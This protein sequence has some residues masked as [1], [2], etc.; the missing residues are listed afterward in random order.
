[1]SLNNR[2]LIASPSFAKMDREVTQDWV[3]FAYHCGRRMPQYD[4]F[5]GLK[6]KSE[7]FRARNMIVEGAQQHNCDRILM[8]DDDMII[9]A[10][11]EGGVRPGDAADVYSFLA[12]LIAHDKDICGILYY[13]RG[14]ECQPV[15]MTKLGEK[16]Y[17]FLRD[18]EITHGLQRV[19]VTGGGCMLIK[20]RIFDRIPYPYFAPEFEF[21]TDIQLCR[22][23]AEKGF[24][25]W[26]DTAI[27][28]GHVRNESVII[29]SENRHLY[30]TVRGVDHKTQF[31]IGDVYTR[32]TQ[33]ALE[34]TGRA[35]QQE[36]WDEAQPFMELRKESGLSDPD[37]YRE[38]PKQ[39]VSRQVWFNTQA[40]HKKLMTQYILA[41]IPNT[42][43]LRI[44]DFGCGIGIP[45]FTLAE[46]GHQVTAMDIRGTGTLEF[47]KWRC[48]K[49]NVPM[50]FIESEGGAPEPKDFRVEFDIIIAMDVLEHI[51][52]W[53]GALEILAQNLRPDGVLFS[54]NAILDDDE[55]AEHYS[56]KNEDFV[57]QCMKAKL[58]P[59]TQISY[60]KRASEAVYA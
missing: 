17:R 41:S 19:D 6:G 48:E 1:M 18:D 35:S 52:D 43:P 33:D 53:Q 11:D 60:R 59:Y 25:V 54:N 21:G 8:L 40:S 34:F 15:L 12:K 22:K 50:T 16:G 36:M 29:T 26:T 20:T 46:K 42:R 24:E 31:V 4:F 51:K 57:I 45:A 44:L 38:F 58:M 14:Q 39:R 56:L 55:H 9:N 13:Q 2:I 23:A 37:W 28:F 27:E 47:L 49:Y 30:Q 3:R 10:F 32:L 5:F 7:Q